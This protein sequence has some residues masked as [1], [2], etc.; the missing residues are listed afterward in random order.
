MVAIVRCG[1]V[2]DNSDGDGESP[3][4]QDRARAKQVRIVHSNLPLSS[5]RTSSYLHLAV[6]SYSAYQDT[7]YL[8]ELAVGSKPKT[9]QCGPHL[10][11]QFL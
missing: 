10:H 5:E 6:D 3:L 4:S 7:S 8:L 9:V 11:N 2:G 1:P